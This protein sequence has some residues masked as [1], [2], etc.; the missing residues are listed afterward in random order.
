L[1]R[2]VNGGSGKGG[3]SIRIPWVVKVTHE[4]FYRAADGRSTGIPVIVVIQF[5]GIAKLKVVVGA[6]GVIWR[7]GGTPALVYW[8]QVV[9]LDGIAYRKG[10]WP[11]PTQRVR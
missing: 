5:V 1:G 9:G 10:S 3:G 2:S 11:P 8:S 4:A 7:I 6:S